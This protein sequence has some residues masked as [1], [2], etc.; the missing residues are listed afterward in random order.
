[1]KRRLVRGL[2]LVLFA[3][4]LTQIDVAGAI[5]ELGRADPVL[6]AAAFALAIPFVV[7]KSER[8]RIT[9]AWT[10][11]HLSGWVAARLFAAGMLAGLVTPGQV[12]DLSKAEGVRREGGSLAGGLTA[13]IAD[14][15]LDL[16]MLMGLA[17]FYGLSVATDYAPVETPLALA[18][19]MLA[20]AG[21]GAV[22]WLGA[23]RA[24]VR[25]MRAHRLGLR[26]EFVTAGA[27]VAV[28]LL[29]FI[30]YC[31]YG[32]RVYLL[33]LALGLD[34][35]VAPFVAA[36]GVISLVS[37]L[38]IT[39]AGIGSRDAALIVVFAEF[40]L[41]AEAAVA[42]SL[43]I[44]SL[45]VVNGALGAAAWLLEPPRGRTLAAGG[46]P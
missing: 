7:A 12:G 19:A 36:M 30:A 29:T 43:L 22:T 31:L 40:G 41:P 25:S 9:L 24:I 28:A 35:P 8:W 37:L 5:H 39:I 38:P 26:P 42:F 14:R 34:A 23:N 11:S 4:L 33:L 2:G 3:V 18:L 10:G 6:V 46:R 44:L 45:H 21:I 32:A 1:M 16:V 17:G 27:V 20:T 15:A 13:S